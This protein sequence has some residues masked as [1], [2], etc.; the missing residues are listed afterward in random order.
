MITG[1][2]QVPARPR[3]S[4]LSRFCD[5]VFGTTAAIL[6]LLLGMIIWGLLF[7]RTG[8]EPFSSTVFGLMFM[9]PA[10]LVILISGPVSWWHHR[11]FK[12][13]AIIFACSVAATQASIGFAW[14]AF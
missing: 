2:A 1:E 10:V 8:G 12:R 13:R 11:T 14:L 7:D 4:G 9:W 3:V 6:A 5:V